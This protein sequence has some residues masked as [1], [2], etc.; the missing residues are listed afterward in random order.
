MPPLTIC[1]LVNTLTFL[2]NVLKPSLIVEQAE[3]MPFHILDSI[4]L[5]SRIILPNIINLQLLI[6]YFLANLLFYINNIFCFY[7]I[8]HSKN[9]NALSKKHVKLRFS[10]SKYATYPEFHTSLLYKGEVSV[11]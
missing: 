9:N 6:K 1:S 4:S 2:P 5:L 10:R 8:M 7:L 3:V 11:G